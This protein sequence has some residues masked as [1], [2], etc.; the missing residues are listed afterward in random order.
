MDQPPL[1]VVYDAQCPLCQ[2]ARRWFE[3][4]S[5]ENALQFVDC[6]SAARIAKAPMVSED[7]C[8]TAIQVVAQ[9][10]DVRAGVEA[11]PL[12]LSVIPRWRWLGRMLG[13]PLMGHFARPAY[14]AIARRRLR[15]SSFLP[16]QKQGDACDGKGCREK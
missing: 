8:R 14:R 3:R 6:R 9:N 13:W 2:R 11:L 7:A 12:L 4:R 15:L 10:G 1:I 16:Y 5:P